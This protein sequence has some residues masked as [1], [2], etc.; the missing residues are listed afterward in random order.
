MNSVADIKAKFDR[1]EIIDALSDHRVAHI[2]EYQK[3]LK[4]FRADVIAEL[5]KLTTK[6]KDSK[7]KT[8]PVAHNL[9]L[10]APVDCLEAYDNL[11]ALFERVQDDIIELEFSEANHIFNDDWEWAKMAKTSNSYYTARG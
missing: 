10:T 8:F 5:K 1:G 9:G 6:A 11:I 2:A 7:S 4:V 3:A